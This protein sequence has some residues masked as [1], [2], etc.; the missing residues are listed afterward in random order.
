[1]C[2][3]RLIIDREERDRHD[4]D[5]LNNVFVQ[6]LISRQPKK[7]FFLLIQRKKTAA[8]QITKQIIIIIITNKLINDVAI[9]GEK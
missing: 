4:Q 5:I 7:A 2:K 9:G 6:I 3:I 1:M 8:K